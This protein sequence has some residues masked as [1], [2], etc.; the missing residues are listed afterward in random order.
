MHLSVTGKQFEVGDALRTHAANE[1]EAVAEKYFANAI[2]ASVGFSRE[3]HRV[4]AQISVHIGRGIMVQ[5]TAEADGAYGAFDQALERIGKQLR[6]YKRRLRD[7]HR[8]SGAVPDVEPAQQ[9][10]LAGQDEDSGE[11]GDG[12][13]DPIVIAEMQTNIPTLSVSE[14]VMHMDLADLPA[15]LFRNGP[16][17]GLNMIYRRQDGNYGW[18]DPENAKPASAKR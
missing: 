4:R 6:R 11:A 9:Y 10:I 16:N 8:G 18:V 15:M 7:H 1:L 17:G 13:Q 3:A 5:G 2:E 14:A 12:H